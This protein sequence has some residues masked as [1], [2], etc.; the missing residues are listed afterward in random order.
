MKCQ[1][2][3]S[4]D[5]KLEYVPAQHLLYSKNHSLSELRSK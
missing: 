4:L 2:R 5:L 1:I 3:L